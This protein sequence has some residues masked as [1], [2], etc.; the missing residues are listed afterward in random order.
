MCLFVF[1]QISPAE[2]T[3]EDLA[4]AFDEEMI[5]IAT[6]GEQSLARAPAVAT[7]ITAKDI[8]AMGAQKLDQVLESVPGLHV[9]LSP[10]RFTPNYSIRGIYTTFN[11]QVLML[12]NGIPITQMWLGDRGVGALPISDISRIEVIRGPGSAVYG[13]DAFAGVINIYTKSAEE[14]AGTQINAFAGSFDTTQASILYG[15]KENEYWGFD[16]AFSLE[17]FET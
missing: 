17:Y 2:S 10:L 9:S 1:P 5:S 16:I 6:G 11:P 14:K 3:E 7:V 4:L 13:A 15:S 8:E 12:M